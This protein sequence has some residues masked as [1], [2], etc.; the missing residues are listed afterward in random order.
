VS[1]EV[2]NYKSLNKSLDTDIKKV[3]EKIKEIILYLKSSSCTQ[4]QE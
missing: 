1:G 4:K 3:D 2:I